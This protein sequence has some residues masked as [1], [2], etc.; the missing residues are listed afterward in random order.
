MLTGKASTSTPTSIPPISGMWPIYSRSKC[1]TM[2]ML[3]QRK[4]KQAADNAIE[5]GST[6]TGVSFDADGFESKV[7]PVDGALQTTWGYWKD[8]LGQNRTIEEKFLEKVE[9]VGTY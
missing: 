4:I 5:A 9:A 7:Y 1:S 2:T 8:I 6:E 3:P